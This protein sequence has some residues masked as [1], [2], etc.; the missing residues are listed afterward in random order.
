MAKTIQQLQNHGMSG[1]GVVEKRRKM[2]VE[3]HCCV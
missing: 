2:F 3:R 1:A